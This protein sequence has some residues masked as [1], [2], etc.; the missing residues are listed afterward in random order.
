MGKGNI[1]VST[2]HILVWKGTIFAEFGLYWL[3]SSEFKACSYFLPEDFQLLSS[4]FVR[5]NQS[6]TSSYKIINRH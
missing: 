3:T 2:T 6:P 1:T 4:F 5:K